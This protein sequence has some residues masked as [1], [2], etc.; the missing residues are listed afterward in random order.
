[1]TVRL[2]LDEEAQPTRNFR[3][4]LLVDDRAMGMRV[5]NSPCG[6][7]LGSQSPRLL[8]GPIGDALGVTS[9]RY[10]Q[11]EEPNPIEHRP[12]TARSLG[13][14]LLRAEEREGR[15]SICDQSTGDQIDS[16]P[17]LNMVPW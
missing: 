9:C 7:T 1:M 17:H 13:E 11:C 14:I 10:G 3:R 12:A 16:A 2:M 8:H 5:R 6:A 15:I 4:T